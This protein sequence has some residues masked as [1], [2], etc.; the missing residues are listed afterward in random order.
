[1]YIIMLGGPGSGKGSVGG[2]VSEDLKLPHIATGD[3]FRAELK[4]ET[5]LGKKIKKYMDNGLLVPD[6]VVIEI[7]ENRLSQDDVKNGAILDGFPRTKDQAI[8]L[9]KF[10]SGIGKKVDA[11]I[12]LDVSDEDIVKRIVKRVVCSNK[13]CGE[14]YNTEFKPSKVEGICDKCGS[15]LIKRADDNEETVM[16]RLNVY[17][18]TSKELLEYYKNTGVLYTVHP[19]IYSKTVLED[20]VSEVEEYLKNK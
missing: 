15:A 13:S 3:I 20:N 2:K 6:E 1:M 14:S 10:L 19:D 9:D 17:H 8:A 12:E 7:V 11:A 4:N 18:E 5:E 16:Q